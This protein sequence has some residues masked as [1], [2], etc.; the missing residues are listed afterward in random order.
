LFRLA[1]SGP[2]GFNAFFSAFFFA[3]PFACFLA[4]NF[5]FAAG[6]S[7]PMNSL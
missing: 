5:F 6:S 4:S 7:Q 1:S 3:L 2:D